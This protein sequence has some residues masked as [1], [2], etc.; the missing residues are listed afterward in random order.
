M[1]VITK[2]PFKHDGKDIEIG[3]QIDLDTK[4][5]EALIERDLVEEVKGEE[6]KPESSKTPSKT[7]KDDK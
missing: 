3:G 6:Q 1:L 4:E 5:A 7:K 2:Q